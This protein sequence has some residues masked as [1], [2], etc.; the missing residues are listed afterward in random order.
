VKML[1]IPTEI[2]PRRSANSKEESV[3]RSFAK[4]FAHMDEKSRGL[5]IHM[6]SKMAN[7]A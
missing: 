3:L 2:T 6:A 4:L 1:N 7:R 5:L